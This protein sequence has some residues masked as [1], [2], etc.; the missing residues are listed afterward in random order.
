MR[1]L[2]NLLIVTLL[3]ITTGCSRKQIFEIEGV[4]HHAEKSTL[5]LENIGVSVVTVLDSVKLDADG[6]FSFKQPRPD[7][8]DFY[9]LR[10]GSQW[11]NLSVD[12]TEKITVHADAAPGYAKNYTVEGSEDAEKIKALTLLQLQ[13]AETFNKLRQEQKQNPMPQE[14]YFSEIQKA[15]QP[16]KD[17][18]KRYIYEN[19][20]STAAY[21]ALFQQINN[22]LILDP[23]NKDDNKLYAIVATSWDLKYVDHPR[24][25]QLHD[26]TISAMKEIRGQKERNFSNLEVK[27][28]LAYFEISLPDVHGALVKLS[29]VIK[30]GKVIVLDFTA[31]QTKFSPEHNMDLGSIYEKYYAKGLDIFQI[32]L[33]ADLNFWQNVSLNIP[34]IC[35]R[36]PETVYSQIAATYNVKEL[37]ATFL[38]NRKGEVVKRIEQGVD[39]DAEIKKV[40]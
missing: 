25:K 15:I 32:S 13:A 31:Y 35:V 26:I 23:Y 16:Y 39:L 17:A 19:P 5:Y 18:A 24:A 7:I 29:D 28:A 6:K 9:R 34:W 8:P 3:G 40:L 10:I 30:E 27:E 22:L 14:A 38:L 20:A 1:L 37:P 21:F 4:V 36:D 2:N 33:D 12:S 11:I